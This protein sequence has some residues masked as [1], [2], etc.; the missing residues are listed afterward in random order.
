MIT[1][2]KLSLDN[3]M[4]IEHA[5][6]DFSESYLSVF[7]G[8][9][10]AG[11]SSVIE[12]IAI[13]LTERKR[14]DSYKDF[15]KH[16]NNVA[17]INMVATFNGDP[18]VFNTEL[19]DKKGYAPFKRTIEYKGIV[20]KNS[21]CSPLL[22]SF[23]L[24]YL[25]HIMFSLQGESN[26]VDL[27]PSERTKVLKRIFDFELKP[28]LDALETMQSQDQQALLVL[29]TQYD[30][31]SKREFSLQEEHEELT[32]TQI[33]RYE[34]SLEETE[35]K[36]KE[37][38]Q[39]KFQQESLQKQY[40]ELKRRMGE[41]SS[42]RK[43]AEEDV[44]QAGVTVERYAND[45]ETY[46]Q[47]LKSLPTTE[48]LKQRIIEREQE[49]A[50]YRD[51]IEKNRSLIKRYHV[52]TNTLNSKILELSNHIEAHSKGVCP[53]CGQATRPEDVPQMEE[54]KQTLQQQLTDRQAE[55]RELDEASANADRTI[56]RLE[57]EIQS[58]TKQIET[59]EA[60]QA[61]YTSLIARAEQEIAE[62]KQLVEH[63]KNAIRSLDSSIAVAEQEF[64]TI[65]TQLEDNE[66]LTSLYHDKTRVQKIL[67]NNNVTR[68]L[69]KAIREQNARLKEEEAEIEDQLSYL[70]QEQNKVSARLNHCRD[71]KRILSVELPNYIIVKACSK[72][73]R[74][75]NS[76][77]ANVKPGMVVRLLQNRS[78]VEFYYS[79]KGENTNPDEWMS[80][81]M[82]SGF[83]RELLSAAWRVAL[84]KAYSLS[85]LMLDE[86]DSAASVGA[87]EKMF[88]ELAT[89]EGFEQ[90]F[91]ISHKPEIVDI[92]RS[93]TE[94]VT[95]YHVA[96]GSFTLQEY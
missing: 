28:Q 37:S 2:Q 60:S 43:Q 23:G 62:R 38:E 53:S 72:L 33:K 63:R 77:I 46:Q 91:I 17:T 52:Q 64:E 48:E 70:S 90:L 47:S 86:I 44:R 54:E 94:R 83:E 29:Q 3:F 45:I 66:D 34:I 65:A 92:V 24:D 79:P 39:R 14:G 26:V 36:I 88:R 13:C 30:T 80:T 55:E 19:I 15:I 8:G 6:L 69:N 32:A 68:E 57:S 74:H 59:N 40:D 81:K 89:V 67:E 27:K 35:R 58:L 22:E 85:I 25:Q 5:D 1:I 50:T 93:E 16:G 11:K 96:E 42:Q 31:L 87:S 9:N 51:L 73:E 84:A 76:F 12:A 61:Q 78:G 95:A 71:A 49:V 82:A 4:N 20:Y 75:I 21:E 41:L 10:G 18:V 7:Y 56:A